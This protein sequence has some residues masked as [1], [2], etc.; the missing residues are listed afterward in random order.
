[1]KNKLI[2]TAAFIFF[3]N[4][5]CVPISAADETLMVN[6]AWIDGDMLKISVTDVNGV[7]SALALR[8][9]DYVSNSGNK[10]Y[11]TIQAVD[12]DGNKSGVIEIDNPYYTATAETTEIPAE[13]DEIPDSEFFETIL[14]LLAPET[15][16]SAVTVNNP[17][18]PDGQ[19]EVV[20]NAL[21]SDGK[22]FF[23]IGTEDGGVFYLIVDRQRNADNVYFLNAVT[24]QDLIAL[25]EKNGKTI[26]PGTVEAV[27][28]PEQTVTAEIS[29]APATTAALEAKPAE[30]SANNNVLYIIMGV[31]VIGI[32]AAAYYFKIVKGKKN[33]P[34]DEDEESEENYGYQDE[35]DEDDEILNDGESDEE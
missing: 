15:T 32:G 4:V 6:A 33:P 24:E 30:K 35:S 13:T 18:T 31:A 25:A 22:E 8:L 21:E 2:I 20:D 1:M 34:A 29:T 14:G 27:E 19:G 23:T 10:K 17:F 12:L 9:S 28:T 11:I 16:E 3:M 7:D 26:N 5:F